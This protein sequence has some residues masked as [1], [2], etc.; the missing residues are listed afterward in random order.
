MFTITF[1]DMFCQ[2]NLFHRKRDN[3]FMYHLQEYL[4]WPKTK[5][6]FSKIQILPF[7]GCNF[8]KIPRIGKVVH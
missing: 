3:L 5:Q 2:G 8:E 1:L 4:Q 6:A 7:L